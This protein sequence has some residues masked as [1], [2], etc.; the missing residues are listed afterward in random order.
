ML[1]IANIN[2]SKER[3]Q[4]HIKK[5]KSKRYYMEILTDEAY[6]DNLTLLANTLAQAEFLLYSLEKAAKTLVSA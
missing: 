4:S 5:V 2:R 3:K 6:A 1:F